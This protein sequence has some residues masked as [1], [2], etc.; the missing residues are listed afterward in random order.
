MPLEI[1]DDF[2]SPCE[3]IARIWGHKENDPIRCRPIIVV[4]VVD[5]HLPGIHAIS[6][7]GGYLTFPLTVSAV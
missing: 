4:D 2:R 3:S 5:V 7:F 1:G 6:L